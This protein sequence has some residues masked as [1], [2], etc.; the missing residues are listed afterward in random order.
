MSEST[1]HSSNGQRAAEQEPASLLPALLTP[2]LGRETELAQLQALLRRSDV[3]L[4]TIT[5]P[6]GMGKTRLAF[7]VMTSL[8]V[9]FSKTSFISLTS[10]N[11]PQWLVSAIA[12]SLEV[13]ESSEQP[14]LTR[15]KDYLRDQNVLLGLDNFEQLVKAG[16]VLI[17]LLM[18]CPK[19]KVLVTSRI[20][21][22]LSGEHEFPLAPLNLPDPTKPLAAQFLRKSSAV[23]LFV[24]KAQAVKPDF[25]LDEINALSVVEICRRLGGLPLAIE[26]AAA[27]IK[28]LSPAALLERLDDQLKIL[29]GGSRDLPLR[30]QTL[31]AS[32]D[33][34]YGLLTELEKTVFRRLAV[35]R[36]GWTLEA[37]LKVCQAEPLT[38]DKILEGL[39]A[40]VNQSLIQV[41]PGPNLET[42]YN[43]LEVIR[44]YAWEQLTEAG[45]TSQLQ[46]RHC[47]W[48][49]ELVQAAGEHLWAG[50]DQAIW[51]GR[52]E[53]EQANLRLALSWALQHDPIKAAQLTAETTIFWD[54]HGYLAEGRRWLEQSLAQ[55]NQ[56]ELP[57]KARLLFSASWLDHRQNE[58]ELASQRCRESLAINRELGDQNGVLNALLKLGWIAL[59]QGQI[60]EALPLLEESMTLARQ[61]GHKYCLA[62]AY[63]YLGLAALLEQNYERAASLCEESVT[64]CRST[65]IRNQFL[66]WALTGR[67]AVA[68]FRFDLEQAKNYFLES[69]AELEKVGDRVIMTYNLMG[70]AV[71]A[72]L[73]E[74][75][76]D[77]VRLFGLAEALREQIGAPILPVFKQ[78]YAMAVNFAA[79]RLEPSKFAEVWAQGRYLPLSQGLALDEAKASAILPQI[80]TKPVQTAS[81]KQTARLTKREVEV[82]KLVA[83]G[84]S[85]SQIARQLMLSPQ[86]IGSY[87]RTIYNK[88]EVNSRSAATRFA[89]E[90]NLD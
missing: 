87:I 38:Q 74:Q 39:A 44:Q 6:G 18:A 8:E 85:N 65:G 3:R 69:S 41:N 17:E 46:K 73:Q 90:H 34:S 1:S 56:L 31:R 75:A 76:E 49:W 22:Q 84:L 26:L 19:L 72:L 55:S 10:L 43:M 33:W 57:V 53:T 51:L 60:G 78:P 20:A 30:Q 5:G 81:T 86:T 58:F 62:A 27:R 80:A 77:A 37:A 28:L 35:F 14:L 63:S 70:L 48:V 67:G 83:D 12:Q 66:G 4:V 29:V 9:D 40:L 2:L 36:A 79:T 68:L 25:K 82:L 61:I 21:L 88:L 24:Q 7:E 47:E 15:V 16:P 11:D 42:H 13:S 54:A 52:L 64:L 45:E 59:T 50:L 89:L 23:N 32:L 71:I